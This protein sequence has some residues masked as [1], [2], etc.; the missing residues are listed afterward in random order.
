MNEKEEIGFTLRARIRS[1]G[2]VEIKGVRNYMVGQD[3]WIRILKVDSGTNIV[4]NPDD[5]I[6]IGRADDFEIC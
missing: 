4:L 6:L 3:G 2:W 1:M 5:V